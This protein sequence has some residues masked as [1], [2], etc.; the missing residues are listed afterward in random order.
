MGQIDNSTILVTV[1]T[2]VYNQAPYLRQ[3]LDGIINQKTNFRF[4]VIVHDDCSSDGSVDI[5]REYAEKYPNIVKPIYEKENQYDCRINWCVCW[6]LRFHYLYPTDYRKLKWYKG[7][8]TPAT[9]CSCFLFNL[10]YLWLD[11]GAKEGLYLN[12]SKC[13]WRCIRILNVHNS[14]INCYIHCINFIQCS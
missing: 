9:N 1:K 8:T 6:N 4:E 14:T 10:G 3:C 5:I 7:T 11:E 13:F 12:Y 2:L